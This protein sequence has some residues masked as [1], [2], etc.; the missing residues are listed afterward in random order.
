MRYSSARSLQ[1]NPLAGSAAILC[2]GGL[3]VIRKEAW[4]FYRTISGVR[5]YW[6]LEEPEGPKGQLT[7]V[8]GAVRWEGLMPCRVGVPS[9]PGNTPMEE[10]SWDSRSERS[11]GVC[12]L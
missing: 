11:A 1:I 4:S 5:L 7:V 10:C 2:T 12:G 6:V 9:Q 3:D 8:S